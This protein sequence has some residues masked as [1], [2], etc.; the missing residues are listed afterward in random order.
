MAN[1]LSK[2]DL[3]KIGTEQQNFATSK[4]DELSVEQALSLMNNEDKK[5]AD[6]IS[7][8]LSGISKAVKLIVEGFKNEGRLFYI[9]AGTSG[10]LGVLDAAECVP[11][12]GVSPE[13]V[14]GIIAGGEK[15]FLKAVEGAEDSLIGA[16]QDLKLKN[17]SNKDVVVGLAAS[18]RT[19]YV[20]GGLKYAA[21]IGAKTISVACTKN[22]EISNLA[23][24][25]I[26]VDAGPEFLTGSTRLKS[27][28]V[29]KLILNMFST[30]AMAQI[31][32]VY[33]NLMVDVQPTNAKLEA[34]AKRIIMLATDVDYETAAKVYEQANKNVKVAIVMCLKN[35]SFEVAS[36]KLQAANGFIRKVV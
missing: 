30:V 5:V 12:F 17:L 35:Y 28:T 16:S 3:S 6:S 7:K 2:I 9:G 25:S 23:D 11:T 22:A 21:E 20:I 18:G 34:R 19:P 10:R 24:V 4:L 32:K 27:G 26:E 15:A 1:N 33:G 8:E 29:Q 31:G 13:M 36:Q 14:Q